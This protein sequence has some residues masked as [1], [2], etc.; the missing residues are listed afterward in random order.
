MVKYYIEQI[1]VS[2][3]EYK[4]VS[5]KENSSQIKVGDI[6]FSYESS[7]ATFDVEA[8]YAG[9]L[10]F[11][12][13]IKLGN[14]YK[15][16][17]LI[18]IISD[19]KLDAHQLDDIFGLGNAT[20]DSPLTYKDVIISKKA[21]KLIEEYGLELEIFKGADVIT[22]ELVLRNIKKNNFNEDFQSINSF[23][24]KEI[25]TAFEKRPKRLAIIGAGKAALQ[26]V[27]AVVLSNSHYITVF[28]DGNKSLEG[29]KILGFPIIPT[30]DIER[31]Y[32]DFSQKLFDEIVISFS[33]D[34]N[35]RK[36]VFDALIKMGIPI[37]NIIHPSAIVSSYVS[38]GIGN[39]IF[40]NTRIGPFSKLGDNNVV[41]SYC[42][43]EH[44]NSIGSHNTF[45]PGVLF[46]GS[47]SV[48][49]QNRFGTGVFIEPNVNIGSNCV[50]A[51]G[52]ILMQNVPNSKL[53][54]NLNKIEFKDITYEE[55]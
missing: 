28:Y 30:V 34:I 55:N 50:I 47:C 48:A 22:E 20:T 23:Y 49:N 11:D 32:D 17:K 8:Q 35:N 3:D 45:G 42:N 13:K 38:M 6:I 41:S 9:F 54:R 46:S 26:V 19:N 53:V 15:V 10:F 24:Y 14:E 21:R 29:K 40:A 43:I 25:E 7:K 2:D 31:I 37:A 16:G 51:S 36:M 5:L 52:I 33:G 27:D 18:A 12:P 4:L 44:H 1:N 39:L